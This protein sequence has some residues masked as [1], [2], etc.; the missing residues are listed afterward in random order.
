VAQARSLGK[1]FPEAPAERSGS[2]INAMIFAAD[3]GL[4]LL[5]CEDPMPRLS[6]KPDAKAQCYGLIKNRGVKNLRLDLC[7]AQ[8]L[9]FIS[10]DTLGLNLKETGPMSTVWAV[11]AA[12]VDRRHILGFLK[13]T[14]CSVRAVE[15]RLFK[16]DALYRRTPAGSR[17]WEPSTDLVRTAEEISKYITEN[18]PV[19]ATLVAAD[20]G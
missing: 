2:F 4:P 5:R 6:V 13:D 18:G 19:E 14:R 3:E 11:P 12:G 16:N 15:V 7:L 20:E 17:R 1:I 8:C 9:A 10:D